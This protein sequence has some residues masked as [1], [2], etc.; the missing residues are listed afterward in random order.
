MNIENGAETSQTTVEKLALAAHS[1]QLVQS[2]R[3]KIS[4]GNRQF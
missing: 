3:K 1:L 4:A 2:K